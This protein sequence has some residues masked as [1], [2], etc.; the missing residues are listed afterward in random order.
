[1]VVLT[2]VFPSQ[3]Y[4]KIKKLLTTNKKIHIFRYRKKLDSFYTNE[5]S[6]HL[7]ALINNFTIF[8]KQWNFGDA[9]DGIISF[10][11]EQN[12]YPKSRK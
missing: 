1:M 11:A 12:S 9:L 7:R 5:K 3:I 10:L 8:F 2:G 4:K 6:F